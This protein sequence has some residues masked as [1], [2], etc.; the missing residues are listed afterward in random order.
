VYRPVG[1]ER[2]EPRR[3]YRPHRDI[4]MRE[5]DNHRLTLHLSGL[6]H[7]EDASVAWSNPP[8]GYEH[9]HQVVL[10]YFG[11]FRYCVGNRSWLLDANRTLFISPGWEFQDEHPVD[12]LGH[13]GVLINPSRE[14]LDEM[15]GHRGPMTC[16][17]FRGV[18]H[19]SSMRLRLLT[20]QML[21][22]TAETHDPLQSDEWVV[23]ALREA[24]NGARDQSSRSSKVID[25]A[26]EFLHAHACERL[27]LNEIAMQVDVTPVY[28]TQEFTRSEGI[29]LYRYQ[30][31][32]RLSRA[33]LELPHCDD[34][35]GLAL[36]LGFS[37]HSHF[38]SAF[39]KAFGL[40]PAAF[41]EGVGTRAL[42]LLQTA[43][44]SRRPRAA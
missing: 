26:K 43:A 2:I 4:S 42:D 44:K 1:D 6:A 10:P 7:V 38:S 23:H 27:P 29:P 39:K 40:T 12:D 11:I 41:R 16:L 24:M 5:A 9:R 3:D 31:W 14:L 32:L 28:L 22:I 15:C 8:Q 19:P 17:A 35:T 18:S 21:R 25:R 30:L 34:I 37:S 13:A 20:Q 36:D 33:L